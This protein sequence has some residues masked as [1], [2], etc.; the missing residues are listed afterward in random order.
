MMDVI[1][2]L[3]ALACA[4]MMIGM[5]VMMMR[6]HGRSTEST[7]DHNP[8]QGTEAPDDRRADAR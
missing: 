7:R 5:A 3:P 1:W 8:P 6:G 2:F 4:G